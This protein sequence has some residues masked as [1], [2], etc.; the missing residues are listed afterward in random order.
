M[1]DM[2]DKRNGGARRQAYVA[3]NETITN[4]VVVIIIVANINV[5][6]TCRD[7][8]ML[9]PSCSMAMAMIPP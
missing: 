8:N 9:A 3:F 6:I 1:Y 2:S 5:C 7:S 4:N